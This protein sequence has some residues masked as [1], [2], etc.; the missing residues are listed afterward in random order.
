MTSTN[1]NVATLRTRFGILGMP[2]SEDGA[3]FNPMLWLACPGNIAALRAYYTQRADKFRSERYPYGIC[4]RLPNRLRLSRLA[5]AAEMALGKF[6]LRDYGKA[7][8]TEDEVAKAIFQAATWCDRANWTESRGRRAKERYP[9]RGSMAGGGD[10]PRA[11]AIAEEAILEPV[12]GRATAAAGRAA[13][14]TDGG[15]TVA[16]GV[17]EALVGAGGEEKLPEPFHVEGGRCTPRNDGKMARDPVTGRWAQPVGYGKAV[18][19]PACDVTDSRETDS[20]P[21][22]AGPAPL[23]QPQP[24]TEADHAAI[25]NRKPATPEPQRKPQPADKPQTAAEEAAAY[26]AYVERHRAFM[27]GRHGE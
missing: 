22:Y 15:Q 1:S 3:I 6:M 19:Y 13:F 18:T 5:D 7:G 4:Y 26:A 2:P 23:P 25:T 24:W 27:T 11:V 20:L 17:R 10:D 12:N 9:Y 16:E 21:R 14:F 8:I